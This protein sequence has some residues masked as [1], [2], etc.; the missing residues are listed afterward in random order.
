MTPDEV[1]CA[2][3]DGMEY[4]LASFSD[5]DFQEDTSLYDTLP[6]DEVRPA[7]LLNLSIMRRP[8][9][10]LCL[11]QPAVGEGVGGGWWGAPCASMLLWRYVLQ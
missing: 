5:P 1:L 9:P 10:L 2:L 3:R 7:L 4:Y 8:S 6:L 11:W